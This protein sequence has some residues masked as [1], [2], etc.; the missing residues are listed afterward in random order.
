MAIKGG[1]IIH[2][3][4]GATIIDRVQTGGPGQVNIPTE[5]IYELG[6]Y[7]SVATIRDTPDLQFSLESFDVSSEVE[8]LLAGAYVGRSVSDA[9]TTAADAT[10]TSATAA[11][12]SADVGRQ[13]IVTRAGVDRVDLVTTIVSV[14]NGTT[15]EMAV[16]ADETTAGADL[17]I[18]PNG[19]DLA[20]A[21]PVDIAS[22]FKA[23]LQRGRPDAGT[24]VGRPAVPLHGVDRPTGSACATTPPSRLAARRHDL[25][26]P[27]RHLRASRSRLRALPADGRTA[28]PAYQAAECRRPAHPCG[29]RRHQAAHLRCGLHRDLRHDHRR[30]R[31]HHGHLTATDRPGPDHPASSTPARP[32]YLTQAVHPDTTVK[33]A[34]VKG[35]DIEIY[36]GGYDPDD[37]PGSRATSSPRSRAVNVEWRV[38]LDKDEEFGNHYAVAYDFDVPAVTGSVDI[39]PRDLPTARHAPHRSPATPTPRKTVGPDTAVPLTSTSSSR[40]PRTATRSSACTSRTPASPCPASGPGAAEA[41]RHAAVRVRRGHPPRLRRLSN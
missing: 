41:H 24:D 18:S 13:V 38:Q 23:G 19:I 17:T 4:N 39:K 40:T 26:Q 5:K 32:R 8:A 29:R 2:A 31:G 9:V 33:P 11:F 10:L 15:V 7:K 35:R 16:A 36:I 37:I 3:G 1:Q 34:A 20:T 6:N 27:R 28:Q 14:T 22:Q 21:V 25:L 12:T 30:R